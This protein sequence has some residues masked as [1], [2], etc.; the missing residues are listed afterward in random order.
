MK[1]VVSWVHLNYQNHVDKTHKSK[2]LYQP[3][4]VVYAVFCDVLFAEAVI[5]MMINLQYIVQPQSW[6]TET[7]S[8][9]WTP[10]WALIK[11]SL[12]V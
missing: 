5:T 6:F 7:R 2:H 11:S 1:R 4:T 3:F 12:S 9:D 10:R 8:Q